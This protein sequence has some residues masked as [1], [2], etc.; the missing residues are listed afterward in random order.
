MT[1]IKYCP[2]CKKPLTKKALKQLEEHDALED[3]HC[4]SCRETWSWN[5]W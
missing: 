1:Q 2:F 4:S 3:Y 5:L